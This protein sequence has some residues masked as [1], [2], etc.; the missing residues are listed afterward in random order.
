MKKLGTI[1]EINKI[2]DQ[3]TAKRFGPDFIY[4]PN[5]KETISRI[6]YNW[7]NDTNNVILDAPTGSGKS[8]VAMAVAGILSEYADATGY[9]CISDLSLLEQ[10]ERDVEIYFPDWAIIKGQHAYTCLVNGYNFVTGDCKLH[11]YDNYIDIASKYSDCAPYCPYLMSR[12]KAL[13]SKVTVC[14]YSWYL[15]QHNMGQNFINGNNENSFTGR[16]FVICDEC[17]KLVDIVQSHFSPTI[18]KD[19]PEKI[20]TLTDIFGAEISMNRMQAFESIRGKIYSEDNNSKLL[21]HL[22]DYV[23]ILEYMVK[24]CNR[25]ISILTADSKIHGDKTKVSYKLLNIQKWLADV[26]ER[27]SS[28][29]NIID[30]CGTEYLVKTVDPISH[31][32]VF[33]CLNESYLL[34]GRFI[35]KSKKRLFM[36]ATVGD[37]GDYAKSISISSMKYDAIKMPSVFDYSNSPIYFINECKMSYAARDESLPRVAEMITKII[38]MYSNVRG[39]IQTG[40]YMFANRLVEILPDDCKERILIYEDSKSKTEQLDAF[41]YSDNKILIGPTLVEG[42]SLNDD[43]CRFQIIMKVPYPSLIDKFVAAKQKHNPRWYSNTAAIAILQGVGR[44]VRNENDW[45][46]TFIVDA[47]FNQLLQNNRSSFPI[48]FLNRIQ[49]ISSYCLPG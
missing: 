10:Y 23:Q 42:L 13:E 17:H 49:E 15:I 44:G 37:F 22:S 38:R 29:V 28:Y 12:N 30:R 6:L 35:N 40:S 48:E 33:N 20:K 25:H 19:D 41:K 1:D 39:V 47:C 34:K 11:G 2:I 27:F 4:R 8:I 16:D 46:V 31:K 21:E 24:D 32:V 43:L 9:I 36:S 45:C 7:D 5:Q 14:T 26:C 3:W 18:T